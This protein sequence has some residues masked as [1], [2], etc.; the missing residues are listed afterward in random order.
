[1]SNPVKPEDSLSPAALEEAKE[2]C[3]GAEVLPDGQ[4]GLA[5][6]ILEARSEGRVL[7]VKLGVD[8]TSCDLHLGHSVVL[9]ALRRFQDHGHQV[10]LIIG[11]FTAQ[12]GD[13]SG[14]SATR[15][16]LTAEQVATNAA[17][18]LEQVGLILE[19]ARAEVVNN[20]DWLGSMDLTKILKL[21]SLVT[22]NQLLAKE[23]FGERIDAQQPVAL[24]ELFYPVLQGFD[25]V[26]VRADVEIGGTDQ[27][28]N[29]LMGRQLQM[30]LGHRPQLAMLLPLLPGTDG[31][32][33][34]SKS[35]SN[36]IGLTDAPDEM[37]GKCMRIPDDLIARW[38]ELVTNLSGAEIDAI[39]A[40]I[41]GGGNP[42][43]AKERLA[44]QLVLQSHG[45]GPAQAALD[46]WRR[47][48]SQRLA[49]QEMPSHVVT[50]PIGLVELLVQ[51]SLA[52]SKNQAR[53]LIKGGGVRLDGQKVSD[54][55]LTVPVPPASGVVLQVGRR[56]F[57]RLVPKQ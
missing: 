56:Q 41:A 7:R 43:D 35:F 46:A 10:V 39:Q 53:N 15:P 17:T 4:E 52:P 33:K 57:A 30:Q 49:P 37:F 18:Y 32:R 51:A 8:P 2:L 40:E 55:N 1:M 16:A 44:Q 11:G 9:R 36:S 5:R 23:S 13:P 47:V 19:L 50:A 28:F 12:I 20:A 27:R 45:T 24:H 22:A 42:R 25:S 29:V 3:R 48:H 31:V 54:Q 14:R 21:A 34:M 6:R 26:Q 38:F